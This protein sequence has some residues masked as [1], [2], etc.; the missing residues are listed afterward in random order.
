MTAIDL[1]NP[2]GSGFRLRGYIEIP[3]PGS[4]VPA[5]RM[6]VRGWA[7][8]GG[9]APLA[10]VVSAE[11]SQGSISANAQ[12]REHK[13]AAAEL[14]LDPDSK[15]GWIAP[16]DVKPFA[17]SKID[18]FVTVWTRDTVL[19]WRF[20]PVSVSVRDVS[21]EIDPTIFGLLDE[22]RP[23]GDLVP[24]D[25]IIVGGWAMTESGLVDEVEIFLDDHSIGLARI[26]MPRPDMAELHDLPHAIL[27]GFSLH[28]DLEKLPSMSTVAK[29]TAVARAGERSSIVGSASVTVAPPPLLDRGRA[30]ARERILALRTRNVLDQTPVSDRRLDPLNLLV[31]THDLGYGGAQL[32]L[33]E[34]LDKVGAGALFDCTVVSQNAGP[35]VKA[36]EKQ[37]IPV[38][39]VD[40]Y[41]VRDIELYE[42]QVLNLALWARASGANAVLV[43]TLGAFIGADVA[44]RLGLPC[45]W[46]IHESW[47]LDE[48]W[49]VNFPPGY[50]PPRV[51]SAA[52]RVLGLVPAVVFEATATKELFESY[53]SPEAARVIPYGIHF[54]DIDEYAEKTS[55]EEA[56]RRLGIAPDQRV[57]LVLGTIEGRK[58]QTLVAAAFAKVADAHPNALL[59]FVGD[60]GSEYARALKEYVRNVGLVGRI[61]VEKVV[62]DTYIWYR[63]ADLFF[64]GSDIESLPRSVLEVMAFRVPV[65]ATAVFGLPELIEDGESGF[66]FRPRDIASAAECLDRALS[67]TPEQLSAIAA[68]GDAIV[69]GR[70][71]S[72]MYAKAIR[73]LI[74]D[75]REGARPPEASDRRSHV[76]GAPTPNQ[77]GFATLDA[78][79]PQ[80]G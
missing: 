54:D 12:L 38:R 37:G 50:V 29:F 80:W 58:L 16:L 78:A 41:K 2:S 60:T 57:V 45:V 21:A 66:L 39:V 25:M 70:H 18:I 59:V 7:E 67:S 10:V 74:D 32:W 8:F 40:D 64:L 20:G 79:R 15:F 46:A 19:P 4:V 24:R 65:A 11:S 63:A 13:D 6:W 72:M 36:L 68:R 53:L 33:T 47:P 51:R 49:K 55:R 56:R 26:A 43:N 62:R 52:E 28:T 14:G 17:G 76:D 30:S 73:K 9:E 22:P 44:C 5:R 61:R 34:L 42:S 1:E 71:N 31:V 3:L 35:L 69:R 75:L 27:S 23:T 48:F 77:A